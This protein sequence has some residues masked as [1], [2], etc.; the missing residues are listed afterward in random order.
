MAR[1]IKVVDQPLPL[2]FA[3]P[4][5]YS[6]SSPQ[7]ASLHPLQLGWASSG[8]AGWTWWCGPWKGQGLPS[9]SGANGQLQGLTSSHRTSAPSWLS[10]RLE[11]PPTPLPTPAT[12]LK[13]LLGMPFSRPALTA[14]LHS[15]QSQQSMWL[16]LTPASMP[17]LYA[18]IA[19][20]PSLAQPRC[21]C[22]TIH[23]H[24]CLQCHCPPN[25]TSFVLTGIPW[26]RCLLTLLRSRWPPEA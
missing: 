21:K 7:Q 4:C 19:T 17:K 24:P 10:C 23:N 15:A 14:C 1:C 12:L 26:R 22:Q 16:Q 6:C 18:A 20:V 5:T 8:S 25:L 9:S 13:K 2:C 3:G 11:P